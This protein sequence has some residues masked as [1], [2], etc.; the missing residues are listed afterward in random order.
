LA[1][2]IVGNDFYHGARSARHLQKGDVIAG[3]FRHGGE[4]AV[5]W[6]EGDGIKGH[7]P[8]ARG[9]FDDG[10][11]LARAAQERGGGIVHMCH[12]L[13][14]MG[15]RLIAADQRFQLQMANRGV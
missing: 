8:G 10:D 2:G 9:V 11:L 6:S 12:G 15:R 13:V 4:N 3:I 14:G 1:R 5:A 7:I